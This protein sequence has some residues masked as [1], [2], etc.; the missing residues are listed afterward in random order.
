[1]DTHHLETVWAPRMLSVLRI[2]AALIFF[3]HGTDK[4][5]GFPD[6]GGTPPAWS[7]GWIAGIIELF[8]GALLIVG[9]FTRPVAFLT[10]GMA[11]AAYFIGHAPE[12][13]YPV[14]NRGDAAI[15]YCFVFLYLVFAGPGPWSL[16]A[17]RAERSRA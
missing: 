5:L 12:S 6:T 9:L 3:A 8:G 11:A 17:L 13:F 4:I 14:I 2:M 10:S 7:L 15:L 1:M 16:D